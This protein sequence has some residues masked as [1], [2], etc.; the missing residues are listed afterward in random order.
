MQDKLFQLRSYYRK[1]KF[2]STICTI[3][4]RNQISRIHACAWT[5]EMQNKL[6][7]IFTLSCTY[8]RIKVN[9]NTS[10]SP[11][12]LGVEGGGRVEW[13][14]PKNGTDSR[15]WGYSP[16][17]CFDAKKIEI[18]HARTLCIV[19]RLQNLSLCWT[20]VKAP[21]NTPSCTKNCLAVTA[22]VKSAIYILEYSLH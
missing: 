13:C 9:W 20:F 19:P 22:Y 8:S 17:F 5:A 6:F 10:K 2:S 16:L 21:C 15:G 1:S 12:K 4:L 18:Y 3:V 11:R 14:N 7:Q